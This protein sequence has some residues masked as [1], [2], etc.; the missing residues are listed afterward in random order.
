MHQYYYYLIVF[1]MLGLYMGYHLMSKQE[2]SPNQIQENELKLLEDTMVFA[3]DMREKLANLY[4]QDQVEFKTLKENDEYLMRNLLKL[5]SLHNPQ[6]RS[7]RKILVRELQD[8]L[9]HVDRLKTIYS[10][11]KD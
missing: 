9:T 10:Q 8:L 5:D 6:L 7:M 1:L 11:N 3:R 2:E 4:N